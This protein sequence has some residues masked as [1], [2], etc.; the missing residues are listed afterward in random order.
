MMNIFDDPRLMSLRGRI[1]AEIERL[2]QERDLWLEVRLVY[3][4]N[5]L[6][7]LV[8]SDRF[9]SDNG[10]FLRIDTLRTALKAL[11]GN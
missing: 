8:G 7:I 1:K 3:R 10:F 5:G 9:P 2:E 6:K 4:N 11:E